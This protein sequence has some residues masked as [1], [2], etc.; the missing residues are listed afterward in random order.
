MATALTPLANLTLGGSQATVTFS[1]ISGAYRDLRLVMQ[2][3]ASALATW[4]VQFNS[5]TGANYHYVTASGDGASTFSV[6]N[7]GANY[8]V[9]LNKALGD[10]TVNWTCSVDVMD[11]SATDKHKS[12]LIRTSNA[13]RATE[14][15]AGRWGSTSA[16]TSL[17][18]YSPG[19]Q[20]F[21]AG[22][23]FALY[24]VSA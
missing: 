10:T 7:T 20:T 22:S 17:V 24:G 19:G 14:T 16:V 4:V 8:C 6:S 15:L 13:A 23:T 18:V 1:S 5:D 21:A 9:L 12:L 2:T 3:Q 11:Y